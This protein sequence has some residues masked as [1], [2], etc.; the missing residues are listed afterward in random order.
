MTNPDA[1]EELRALR[2]RGFS[3]LPEPL[4]LSQGLE[5]E[6]GRVGAG[7]AGEV[8]AFRG[9][10]HQVEVTAQVRRGVGAVIA[11]EE[12]LDER[13]AVPLRIPEQLRQHPGAQL[14]HLGAV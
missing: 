12:F 4:R 10:V 8:V 9:V 7:I 11:F 14:G 5:A 1:F 6:E 13:A 2:G 3:L